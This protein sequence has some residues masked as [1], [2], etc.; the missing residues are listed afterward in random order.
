MVVIFDNSWVI[1]YSPI[2]SK[3]FG[4]H[5]NVES[6]KYICKYIVKALIKLSSIYECVNIVSIGLN[7]HRQ[8]NT[9]TGDRSDKSYFK[10]LVKRSNVHFELNEVMAGSS[11]CIFVTE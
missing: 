5:I 10:R 11:L 3:M 6:L 1:S 8:S 2:L 4:V 9:Q 7:M